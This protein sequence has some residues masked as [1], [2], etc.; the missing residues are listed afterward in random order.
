[1]CFT[2]GYHFREKSEASV[3]IQVSGCCSRLFKINMVA[4]VVECH[5]YLRCLERTF[6]SAGP[7]PRMPPSVINQVWTKFKP[8]R[9]MPPPGMCHPPTLNMPPPTSKCMAIAAAKYLDLW[10]PFSSC[11]FFL[12]SETFERFFHFLLSKKF[13]EEHY[14]LPKVNCCFNFRRGWEQRNDV[15]GQIQRSFP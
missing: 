11:G 2:C 3:F 14:V 12:R 8:P 7:P 4:T 1:M 15:F 6:G 10:G 9:A 13:P 5:F